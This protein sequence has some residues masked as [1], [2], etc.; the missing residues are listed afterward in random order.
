[1]LSKL[2]VLTILLSVTRVISSE[3]VVILNKGSTYVTQENGFDAFPLDPERSEQRWSFE[4]TFFIEACSSTKLCDKIYVQRNRKNTLV[5]NDASTI[6][7]NENIKTSSVKI[8]FSSSRGR[9]PIVH[10]SWIKNASSNVVQPIITMA[11]KLDQRL[12]R[13]CTFFDDSKH[14]FKGS[15]IYSTM[16]QAVETKQQSSMYS[17]MR[18]EVEKTKSTIQPHS[19][20]VR[21]VLLIFSLIFPL[22]IAVRNTCKATTI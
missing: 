19:A 3:Y 15:T 4:H 7:S 5:E 2:S 8:N 21:I 10:F 17:V 11:L 16:R 12:Q 9:P 22:Y 14:H 6:C 20:D 18:Q 13:T 1:M